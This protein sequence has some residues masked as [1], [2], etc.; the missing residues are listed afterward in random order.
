MRKK[1]S[2]SLKK[3]IGFDSSVCEAFTETTSF[4]C[5]HK[6]QSRKWSAKTCDCKNKPKK[7]TQHTSR[8]FPVGKELIFFKRRPQNHRAK[9][10]SCF[11]CKNPGHWASQCPMRLKTKSQI[12]IMD[13]FTTGYDPAEWDLVSHHSDGEYLSITEESD[14]ESSS[15]HSSNHSS[16]YD[17]FLP[18]DLNFLE[19]KMISSFIDVNSLISQCTALQQK[20]SA[21]ILGQFQL[22]DRYASY[23][24][25]LTLQI[26]SL[27]QPSVVTIHHYTPT[28]AEFV[29]PKPKA[30]SSVLDNE[31]GKA[32]LSSSTIPESDSIDNT[33]QRLE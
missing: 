31:K 23:I 22:Y 25:Q 28:D 15:D 2:K 19:I 14:F 16:N 11:I 21:L 7:S 3:H 33:I 30:P 17:S 8:R 18:E 9:K 10:S 20:L 26:E 32:T 12:K 6:K 1:T 13:L 4:G 29:Q 27:Q 5:T 24:E